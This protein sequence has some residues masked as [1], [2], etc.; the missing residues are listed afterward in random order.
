MFEK[1][2]V[3]KCINPLNNLFKKD[4]SLLL[5]ARDQQNTKFYFIINDFAPR[6]YIDESEKDRVFNC[7]SKVDEN[8]HH[9]ITKNKVITLYLYNTKQVYPAR[10]MF[11]KTYEA[12][13]IFEQVFLLTT[14]LSDRFNVKNIENKM[15]IKLDGTIYILIKTD[16]IE[17]V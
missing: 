13:I 15:R 4:R 1:I 14:K 2:A 7:E 6:I 8:K 5:T 11:E 16:D 12:D 3:N 10:N 9:Y 17:V